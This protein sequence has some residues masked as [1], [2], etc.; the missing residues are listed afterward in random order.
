MSQPPGHDSGHRRHAGSVY[1]L[2]M[3]ETQIDAAELTRIGAAV[4][5]VA[6]RMKGT[7]THIEGWAYTGRNAVEGSS[8][9]AS[10]MIA[11]A[12]AWSREIG[13]L[14]GAVRRYGDDLVRTATDYESYDN[15]TAQQLRQ[16]GDPTFGK[17]S[18]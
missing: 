4:G 2:E 3:P 11:A 16:I 8:V 14:A 18:S 9:C 7:S 1:G 10:D 17:G 15:L 5:K 6:T 12:H 13:E